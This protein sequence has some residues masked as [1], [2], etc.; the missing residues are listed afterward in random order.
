MKEL[1]QEKE[2]KKGGR[3]AHSDT[4][5]LVWLSVFAL[6]VALSPLF[7]KLCINGHDLE[8]HLLRIESL[9]E[10]ILMGKPFLRVN[11]LFFG[12]AG[13]ASSMFY[14]DFLLYIP[15]A[16]RALGVSINLSYH[17]FVGVCIIL[18]YFSTFYC[19]YRLTGSRK[20][21]L[22]TAVIL[23]LC[24]YHIEDIYVR[25]AV[26]EFTAFIFVP[27]VI[28]G[29]YNALYEEADRVYLL[30]I[31]YG[32]VL[33]CHTGTF[34]LCLVFGAGAIL[35][36]IL[37][38][39]FAG[40]ESRTAAEGTE[41]ED[42]DGNAPS[43]WRQNSRR[44][45]FSGKAAVR[46]VVT[47]LITAGLTSF[48]W[49]PLMEQLASDTFYVS[50]PWIEPAQEARKFVEIFFS[51]FPSLGAVLILVYILRI[52]IISGCEL[53]NFE[54]QKDNAP[55]FDNASGKT[56]KET[57]P[58]NITEQTGASS[59]PS[60]SGQ[61]LFPVLHFADMLFVFGVLFALCSTNFFPWARLGR[62]MSFMQFPWRFFLMSS[63]CLAFADGILIYTLSKTYLEKHSAILAGLVVLVFALSAFRTME[64]GAQGYYDYS[65]DYYSYK[66]FTA[67]VIAGEWLPVSV[68][69]RDLLLSQSEEAIGSD[70]AEVVFERYK[71]ELTLN[72]DRELSYID[73]PFVYYKGYRAELLSS[74][75]AAAQENPQ[76]PGV[77][78]QGSA[79]SLKV[80]G[81]G[82]NG[83]V[84]VYLDPGTRGTVRVRYGGTSA[85]KVSGW[86]SILSCILAAVI[87][88][89]AHVKKGKTVSSQLRTIR[90]LLGLTGI[91][92]ILALSI[93]GCGGTERSQMRPDPE[94]L[95]EIEDL[96]AGRAGGQEQGS[97]DDSYASP[98]L[99]VQVNGAGFEPDSNKSVVVTAVDCEGISPEQLCFSV[100]KQDNGE[101]VYRGQLSERYIAEED[102]YDSVP[103]D[104]AEEA[105][106]EKERYFYGDFTEFNEPGTYYISCYIG[107]FYSSDSESFRIGK[108]YYNN[109]LT[110]KLLYL[111]NSLPES[112]QQAETEQEQE[113][114]ESRQQGGSAEAAAPDYKAY[115]RIA[116][117]LLSYEFYEKGKLGA[118]GQADLLPK[119]LELA[120]AYLTA[121]YE[122]RETENT[123]LTEKYLLSAVSSMYACDI[124]PFDKNT[125]KNFGKQAEQTFKEAEKIFKETE[126]N[127]NENEEVNDQEKGTGAD[128][129]ETV[130][131]PQR[132]NAVRFWAVAQLY[133]YKNDKAYRRLAEELALTYYGEEKQETE[134]EQTLT[135]KGFETENP[136][137]LG[138]I[139]YLTTT[140]K[141]D[142]EL[143][144]RLMNGILSDAVETGQRI[145]KGVFWKEAF[146]E[147]TAAGLYESDA[148]EAFDQ[149]RLLCFANSVSQSILYV[150]SAEE[151]YGYFSGQTESEEPDM[152]ILNGLIH[153]YIADGSTDWPDS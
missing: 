34:V 90:C 69:D 5:K 30:G 114:E 26:G 108:N 84:R 150:K 29:I 134:R 21:G 102:G 71:N 95:R 73:A 55:G 145:K 142:T 77:S 40:K 51:E 36:G 31:G 105:G 44:G 147:G 117:L 2:E 113:A 61:E 85:Q 126:N 86:V 124:A 59:E 118:A 17:I 92:C 80:D 72:V 54:G 10:G 76:G 65:L 47:A 144:E 67:N 125:A 6:L 99:L 22:I 18:C 48:Y 53:S 14:P 27:F 82:R 38:R 128:S 16:L 89:L 129:I 121:L 152:F 50:R 45:A 136:V 23:T 79:A 19:G 7:T 109:R 63:I 60:N 15:A 94:S 78:F 132:I 98:E 25:A 104:A 12:G 58:Q 56:I 28:Y 74:D 46:V 106:D 110:E 64:A 115:T 133:R 42:S 66:P 11:V 143:S 131:Q 112:G 35:W 91:S 141:V 3:P 148:A 100:I 68:E 20:A 43:P 116:D 135:I 139:A 4:K 123:T 52:F 151:L 49:L 130:D 9:K 146:L 120:G 70:G 107:D 75:N 87:L 153:S 88:Y 39:I 32:G 96:L 33:L 111:E 13:Y 41:T 103:G 137:Y 140:N 81:N 57:D 8:Y 83:L 62:F 122:S 37:C 24:N 101:E 149:A 1:F 97:E 127:K 93:T 119:S 138:V